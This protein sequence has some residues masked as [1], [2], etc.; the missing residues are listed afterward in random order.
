MLIEEKEKLYLK[1]KD[2][3]YDG[4]PIMTDK[5]FDD[6]E[7]EL[8]LWG[9]KVVEIV[10][11]KTLSG[12]KKKYNHLSPMLSLSKISSEDDDNPPE[13][14]FQKWLK[15]RNIISLEGTPKFDGNSINLIYKNGKFTQALTRGDKIYGHDVTSKLKSKIPNY[16]S[17]KRD[18]EI[19]GE[20]VMEKA[21]FEK[22]YSKKVL[23]EDK[24]KDN[25]RNIVAGI[26]SR[27][28]FDKELIDDMDFVAYELRYHENKKVIFEQNY[29]ERLND[30][31]FKLL[32]KNIII[33]CLKNV[34]FK[35][36]YKNFLNFRD[37]ISKYQ[38]DGFVLKALYNDDRQ[39]LGEKEH[40]PD[41]AIAIK[42]K[43]KN[44]T[45]KIKSITWEIGKT[46]EYTPVAELEP[47]E[48]DGCTVSRCSLHNK[49][50]IVENKVYPGAEISLVKAGD[51]IPQVE[52]VIKPSDVDYEFPKVCSH[53]CHDL[54]SDDIRIV[55]VNPDCDGTKYYKFL[56]A[57]NLLKLDFF[58]ER[59]IRKIYETC[60]LK[61]VFEIFNTNVFNKN[62]LIKN[63]FFND[64]KSTD[65]LF[66]ELD[67]IVSLKLEK[68]ILMMGIPGLGTK[69]APQI[70]NM[71]SHISY[72]E[73][74]LTKKYFDMFCQKEYRVKLND[75][76]E[77]LN[78]YGIDII[79]PE[80]IKDFSNGTKNNAFEMTGSP[81]P[82]FETKENFEEYAKRFGFKHDS[83][84][85]ETEF[86]LTD[87]YDS[88]SSKMKKAE[89]LNIKII[90]Y[91]DFKEKYK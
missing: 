34:D 43:P 13:E 42:F 1:A 88:N 21:I 73:K 83:L 22:K 27:D 8:R 72:S 4:N 66:V 44:T 58:G 75:I 32:P 40:H 62:I 54:I 55:C 53:C 48:L 29:K 77:R 7:D 87:S 38:L 86:L 90:T 78:S 81:K 71:I 18:I 12:L 3:Y 79:L 16:I 24:G 80:E 65:R 39:R 45:T 49:R 68:I 85:K 64:G 5:E 69:I 89:K 63:R 51:I 61:D 33:N 57:L 14:E 36:I 19:R 47:V 28:D 31:G 76:L 11:T 26:L 37:N 67:K 30:F 35:E 84:S 2:T 50:Y 41:W 91:E 25:P 23:G 56:Y 6:L 74:G 70:A 15:K 52:T 59:T 20:A 9:S 82:F 10:G 17:D 60:N 46:G